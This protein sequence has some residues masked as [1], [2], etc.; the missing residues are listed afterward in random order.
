MKTTTKFVLIGGTAL[1]LALA[2]MSVY[3]HPEGPWGGGASDDDGASWCYGAG[4]NPGGPG[5]GMGPGSG[6]GY[7]MGYGRHMGPGDG[8]RGG[9]PMGP[10]FGRGYG[11]GPIGM[12]QGDPEAVTQR[13][14]DLKA[15]LGITEKQNGAWQ[16][17]A[18]SLQKQAQNR[19]AWFDKMHEA[20]TA[21]TAPEWFAQRDAAMKQHLGDMAVAT[22]E[23]GK[24][25][26]TLTPEQRTLLDRGQ[27]AMGRRQALR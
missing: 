1:T 25:Y 7:G 14:N 4:G 26:D 2:G 21:N 18:D 3:A 16:G 17:F 20:K 22:A 19:Q 9:Y 24:L 23:L 12:F 6:R 15:T 8:M 13:L 10:G 11:M 27:F 5:A